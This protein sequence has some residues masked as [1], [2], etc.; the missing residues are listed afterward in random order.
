MRGA[1]VTL[2]GDDQAVLVPRIWFQN[3][4]KDGHPVRW[5]R[6]DGQWYV[7]VD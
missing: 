1:K 7:D 2:Q 3:D 5:A 6:I 4:W